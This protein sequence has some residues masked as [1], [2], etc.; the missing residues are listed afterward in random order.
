MQDVDTSLELVSRTLTSLTGS[1]SSYGFE[2]APFLVG[3]YNAFVSDRLKLD[4]ATAPHADCV[5]ICI[6]SNPQMFEQS[7]LPHLTSWFQS[8]G[9]PSLGGA[10]GGLKK[11]TN[12]HL[13][14]PG[15]NDP[16]D[17]SVLL[18]ITEGLNVSLRTL[19]EQLS[20]DE[21]AMLAYP[22]F[23]TDYAMRPVTRLPYVHVQ[24]AGHVSGLAYF[25]QRGTVNCAPQF[26]G[27]NPGCSLH[28][29]YGGWFGFR[30]IVVFPNL[31]CPNLPRPVPVS[32]LPPG[33]PPFAPELLD[34]LLV[35][36]RDHWR[37]NRWRNFGLPEDSHQLYTAAAQCFFN[38]PPSKRAALLESWMCC[39]TL[40]SCP[41]VLVPSD[42][43]TF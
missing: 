15:M 36:F 13:Q 14:S 29:R 3:W 9:V 23:I 6:I 26:R 35:E 2:F 32:S 27:G 39:S 43:R 31:R 19:Q 41:S 33:S 42:V 24:C 12:G 20:P 11:Q 34:R 37:E 10:L 1:L 4:K 21:F 38:T 7:F 8:A 28:P 25:H 22:R 30:G 5:V 18:R 40:N 17:W 16:L